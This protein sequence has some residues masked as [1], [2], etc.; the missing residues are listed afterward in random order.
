VTARPEVTWVN[1]APA[2]TVSALDRGL[3]YGDGLFE[4]ISC[5]GGRARFLALHLD[6]LARG[7]A[8]LG[9]ALPDAATLRA[10]IETL[11]RGANESV[12]KLI[13]T[14][15]EAK[16]RG[17]TPAG[18]EIPTRIAFRYA[19][20][21]ERGAPLR[22]RTAQMRLGENPALAGMRHL[23][24]LEQV[25][26]RA[27]LRGGAESELLL[28]SS[29]GK[30]VSGT[31]ANVFLVRDGRLST[32]R[33]DLCGVA[34]VMRQVVMREAAQAGIEVAERVIE[35]REIFEAGEVFFTNARIGAQPVGVLD[36]RALATG[37]LTLRVQELIAKA[38]DG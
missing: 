31:M 21:A 17:Y 24:R 19:S 6:R 23:N 20:P 4:T 16:A 22:V 28:F 5:R 29:S 10:E 34:G 38:A 35:A 27:E 33:V 30:L 25:L 36:G 26:A 12:V 11:A 32:P 3:H 37:A 8:R 15:G 13:V 2:E 1:G 18:D 14:R 9:M 7:C